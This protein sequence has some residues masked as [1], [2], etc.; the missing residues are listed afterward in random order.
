MW[1]RS[2]RGSGRVPAA[3]IE[4]LERLALV[5]FRSREAVARL[6]KAIN[7]ADQLHAVDTKGVEP[8][9]LGSGRVPAAKIEHLERLALVNFRSRE[10]VARLEK[11]IN[12]AD[13]LHAVDTK[14]VEPMELESTA[15]FLP[16]YFLSVNH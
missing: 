14:G 3:K 11:A 2:V 10:A 15:S 9:E 7:F 16:P 12:F 13:Q 5:N 1:A 8:M 4:H 6:E